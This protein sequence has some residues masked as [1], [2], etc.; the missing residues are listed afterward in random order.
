MTI[1]QVAYFLGVK[2]QTCWGCQSPCIHVENIK[3]NHT[4]NT[5]GTSHNTVSWKTLLILDTTGAPQEFADNACTYSVDCIHVRVHTYIHSKHPWD[6]AALFY[7]II[8]SHLARNCLANYQHIIVVD[9][10]LIG[11][12][13]I[14]RYWVLASHCSNVLT[15]WNNRCLLSSWYK[16]CKSTMMKL[17]F[18]Y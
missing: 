6:D 17:S 2:T 11:R 5:Y 16:R 9:F 1:L 8:Y 13:K 7:Y 4:N 18:C 15:Y 3:Q 12:A 14:V 10:V